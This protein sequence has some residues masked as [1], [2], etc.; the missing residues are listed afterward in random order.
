ML[1]GL[2]QWLSSKNEPR[3]IDI[4]KTWDMPKIC[5]IYQLKL[6]ALFV[7]ESWGWGR[8]GESLF[9]YSHCIQILLSLLKNSHQQIK[10]MFKI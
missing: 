10:K 2:T 6:G 9:W 5:V 4:W 7:T 1:G 8:V 3:K